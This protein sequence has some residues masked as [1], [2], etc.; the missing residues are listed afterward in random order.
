M[1]L[2]SLT[3]AVSTVLGS[4][5]ARTAAFEISEQV[6][7][8][9][10]RFLASDELMGRGPS[11]PGD[12][13]TQAYLATQFEALGLL[14]AGPR[15]SYLQPL[16]LLGVTGHPQTLRAT[17]GGRS[18]VLRY[19]E[20]FMAVAGGPAPVSKWDK[21]ELWFV[22]YG[23]E[24]PEFQWNDYKG[25]DLRGK[26]LVMLNNDPS[27]DPRLFAGHERLWYGRWDYKYEMAEK[28]G[29]AGA[30]IVHTTASA[31]YPWQVVQTSWA[32]EQF[33]LAS[34]PSRPLAVRAWAREDAVARLLAL[35]GHDW[36]ALREKAESRDFQPVPLNIRVSTSFRNVVAKKTTANVLGL[37]PGKDAARSKEWVVLTAHHDHL[38]MKP[39]KAKSPGEDVIYNG[40]VDNASGVAALLAIARAMKALPEAPARTVLFAA[41]AAE[42]QGLLGSLYLME[43]P[44]VAVGAMAANL[45]FDGL[46]V[47]GKT[48][49]LTV[50][51]L[52]KSSLDVLIGKVA[53]E[54][55]R[56]VKPDP[57]ADRGFFYRSDQFNFARKGVP[58]VYFGGGVDFVGQKPG[59]GS[60]RREE[61]EA[62]HYHQVS[63]EVSPAWSWAGAVD[64][65][66]LYFHVA[67]SVA[68]APDMPY[69]NK[70]NEFE[71][72]GL[73][74]REAWKKTVQASGP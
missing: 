1:S 57:F 44:P 33:S 4:A 23:I 72:S 52:G 22:G 20:D 31:G 37:L 17:S 71:A 68:N 42:E 39:Q 3:L 59:F 9:H 65:V 5:E 26:V 54:Q 49:D 7:S 62:T 18:L 16:E 19:H 64:D 38:G 13:L 34:G 66:R 69:W 67:L 24:A 6:L 10:T 56:I 29:A 60:R 12:R 63:D 32:G 30:I 11:T 45:N 50:I 2:L 46:N 47:W 43:N 36:K 70:G 40:A 48:R 41:V 35:G 8:G 61:W 73:R 25:Q 21:A 14:P 53:A 27:A 74:A 28:V 51:G 58:S 15:A 55:G